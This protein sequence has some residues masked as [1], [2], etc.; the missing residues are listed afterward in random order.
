MVTEDEPNDLI[1]ELETVKE[2][3]ETLDSEYKLGDKEYDLEYLQNQFDEC[4]LEG[5]Q[6][7]TLFFTKLGTINKKFKKFNVK[8]I[9]RI[10]G[11]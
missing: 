9:K 4:V 7:P 6:N 3:K 11:N 5:K 1:E 8:N 10:A 2:M